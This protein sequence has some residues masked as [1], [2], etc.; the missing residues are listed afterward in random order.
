MISDGVVNLLTTTINELPLT[1]LQTVKIISCIGYQVEESTIMALDSRNKLLSFNMLSELPRAVAEGI[2]EKAGPV[3][4]VRARCILHVNLE[5]HDG[6]NLL[7][8]IFF[9]FTH[10][11][12]KVKYL[13]NVIS[14]QSY[15]LIHNGSAFIWCIAANNLW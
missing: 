13:H 15:C 7:I 1:L 9:K 4:Q 8:L 5:H 2:L 10:D 11:L 14:L 3:Y 6:G 12:L